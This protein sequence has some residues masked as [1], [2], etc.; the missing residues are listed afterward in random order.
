VLNLILLKN[1]PKRRFCQ[2]YRRNNRV[3]SKRIQRDLL[4]SIYMKNIFE[5]W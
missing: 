3:I 4:Y 2:N 1:T 5:K